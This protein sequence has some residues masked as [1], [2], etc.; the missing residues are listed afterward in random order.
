MMMHIKLIHWALEIEEHNLEEA[1]KYAKKA[2]ALKLQHKQAADWCAEMAKKHVEFNEK[3]NSLLDALCKELTEATGGGEI[4]NAM[5]A[6]ISERRERIAE[7]TAEVNSL[8][9]HLRAYTCKAG[10]ES[11]LERK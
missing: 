5:K 2:H 7:E 1:E 10:T 4:S 9:S 8:I 11:R 6:T 3:A